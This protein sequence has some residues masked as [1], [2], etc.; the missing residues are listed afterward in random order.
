MGSPQR[1][2]RV[3]NLRD[4]LGCEGACVSR[5]NVPAG[6]HKEPLFRRVLRAYIGRSKAALQSGETHSDWEPRQEFLNLFVHG[7]DKISLLNTIVWASHIYHKCSEIRALDFELL[8]KLV[9]FLEEY[10]AISKEALQ[11]ARIEINL[12]ARSKQ[13]QGPWTDYNRNIRQHERLCFLEKRKPVLQVQGV[14][15]EDL[16]DVLEAEWVEFDEARKKAWRSNSHQSG[17]HVPEPEWPTGITSEEREYGHAIAQGLLAG[18]GRNWLI[19]TQLNQTAYPNQFSDAEYFRLAVFEIWEKAVQ[20]SAPAP[21]LLRHPEVITRAERQVVRFLR[22]CVLRGSELHWDLLLDRPGPQY[23]HRLTKVQLLALAARL[24]PTEPPP[25]QPRLLED[26][27]S[28]F[29]SESDEEFFS[30]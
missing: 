2:P 23:H 12:R 29:F 7:S 21:Q 3:E 22:Q 24:P 18:T 9:S 8:H 20:P 30:D 16:D 19:R 26:S 17:T 14:L 10:S 27:D 1:A 25:P 4:A 11:D 28:S 5:F 13:D 6:L 15:P